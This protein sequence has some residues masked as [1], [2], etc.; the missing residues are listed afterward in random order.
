MDNLFGGL[1]AA[2]RQPPPEPPLADDPVEIVM[3]SDTPD[4][5]SVDKDGVME[6]K[7]ADGSITIDTNPEA[8]DEDKDFYANLAEKINEGDLSTIASDLL[9]AIEQDDTGRQGWIDTRSEGVQLLGFEI[10][11][12][13]S[14]SANSAVGDG[15]SKVNHPLLAEAVLRFQAN[16]RGELLPTEG[17]VKIKDDGETGSTSDELAA[18]LEKDFNHYLT[19]VAT[20]YYPDTDRML[21]WV[22]LGGCGFKKVYNCPIRR[23]PVSES[24]DA[25]DIIVNNEAIDLQS[26]GRI[27]HVVRMRPSVLKRMQLLGEYRDID[28]PTMGGISK[29]NSVTEAIDTVQG[30]RSNTQAIALDSHNRERELYETLAE[31]DIP[32]YE[33]R[34]EKSGKIT[35]LPLPYRVTIDKDS[36]EVLSLRR[37]WDEDDDQCM[38]KKL[39]VKYPFVPG[40]GFYDLGLLHILGNSTLAMTAAW[41]EMLDAGAYNCFPGFLVRKSATRQNTNEIRVNPGGAYPIDVPMGDDI[42]QSVMQLPY[43]PPSATLLQLTDSIAQTAQRVGGT[44]ELQVG[45]GKMEAPVGT[46]MALIEQASKVID[47]VHKRLHAAQAEEFQLLKERF[48]EDPEALWRHNKKSKVLAQLKAQATSEG[49]AELI[50]IDD[51][52]QKKLRSRFI[53]AL[54]DVDLV[55]QADPNTSSHIARLMRAI[56]VLQM[57][58]MNPELYDARKVHIYVGHIAGELDIE[59]LLAPPSDPNSKQPD[60]AAMGSLFMGQAKMI[61][62][63]TKQKELEQIKLP[64]SGRDFQLEVAKLAAAQKVQDSKLEQEKLIHQADFVKAAQKQQADTQ[65]S[66]A[67]LQLQAHKQKQ[68]GLKAAGDL[69]LRKDQSHKEGLRAAGD[70]ML[71]KEQQHADGAKAAAEHALKHKQHT[72]DQSQQHMDRLT[73]LHT[74]AADRATDSQHKHLDRQ[75]QLHTDTADRATDSNHQN[76][77]RRAQIHTSAAELAADVRNRVADRAVDSQHRHLDR[78]STERQNAAKVKAAAVKAKAKPKK[79]P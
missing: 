73:Q 14:P 69:M 37:N 9:A 54:A 32:G 2:Y 11:R 74:N 10:K 3:D 70:L 1:G 39:F 67:E 17:P 72:D 66:A 43:Q 13:G 55:P 30:I 51:A 63:Q 34:D 27:T 22:G 45:E 47:A 76:M 31:L 65:I 28:L 15:T 78:A 60:P 52:G 25:K 5:V 38:A 21:F 8:A 48:M 50:A 49:Q 7:H 24:V 59:S 53:A 40:L 42:R 4:A 64:N 19:A 29:P 16:A 35:G 41:R 71:R 79:N 62:A 77:D 33:H 44:A 23:R 20:E 26:A 6:I 61:E 12:P 18:S 46:T 75:A 58:Q 68:D 57:M 56:G 36:R